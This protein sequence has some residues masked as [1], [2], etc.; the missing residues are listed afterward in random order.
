MKLFLLLILD[1]IILQ[2]LRLVLGFLLNFTWFPSKVQPPIQMNKLKPDFDWDI[3]LFRIAKQLYE[4]L[5]R[6]KYGLDNDSMKFL[7]MLSYA[8]GNQEDW[9]KVISL[10]TDDGRIKR[11]HKEPYPEDTAS[12]STDM[13]SGFILAVLGRLD[14]LTEDERT[15]LTTLFERTIW[16]GFP[17]QITSANYEKEKLFSRSHIWR[18]WWL[19]GKEEVL[20]SM[21]WLALG[22]KITKQWKY[23]IAYYTFMLLQLP[24]LLFTTADAQI[25]IKRIYQVSAHN[26]HSRFLNFFVGKE[27]TNSWVFKLALREAYKRHGKYNADLLVLVDKDSELAYNLICDALHKG[28]HDCP[29]T[30]TYIVPFPPKIEKRA[31][32]IMPPSCRGNDYVWERSTI[33][34]NTLT[35]DYR[36]RMGLD[37][38]FPA[39]LYLRNRD[40]EVLQ[41]EQ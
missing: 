21:A 24:T 3:N 13:A 29:K 37:V 31:P 17:F 25:W 4:H 41:N 36:Q 9:D 32:R 40:N 23:V 22:Y 7:G 12:F 14:L 28:V 20:T 39:L 8:T 18:L 34:G 15:K 16:K 11:C 30:V 26:T 2:P 5:D 6:K 19:F 10:V 38:I 1:S 33:K 27:L 35:Y